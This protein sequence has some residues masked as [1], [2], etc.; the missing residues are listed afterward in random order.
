M[1]FNGVRSAENSPSSNSPAENPR[2]KN[3]PRWILLRKI[4]P[5]KIPPKKT[6]PYPFLKWSKK[7]FRKHP[8]LN[9]MRWQVHTSFLMKCINK[10]GVVFWRGAISR[11]GV[12]LVSSWILLSLYWKDLLIYTN[13]II[14]TCFQEVL[15]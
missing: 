10:Y 6:L 7:L 14:K 5:R 13:C 3:S 12:L 4:P 1:L 11:A 8:K 15:S 2:S 9:F